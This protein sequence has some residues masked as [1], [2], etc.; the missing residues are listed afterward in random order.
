MDIQQIFELLEVATKCVAYFVNSNLF[1]AFVA[2]GVGAGVG[3][4]TAQKIFEKSSSKK[5]LLEEIRNTNAS[6]VLAF[7]TGNTFIALKDQYVSDLYNN[8][9]KDKE[10]FIERSELPPNHPD[11]FFEFQFN[12]I[13]INSPLSHERMLSSLMFEKL[14]LETKPLIVLGALLR[15]LESLKE[16]LK[17]RNEFI[18]KV[19]EPPMSH[20]KLIPIYFG[21]KDANGKVDTTYSDA[22]DAVYMQCDDCIFYAV[23]LINYLVSHGK[24]LAE[25][26][27][28]GAPE[29]VEPNFAIA[30][31]KGL[32]PSDSDYE[33]WLK[34]L[35]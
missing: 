30:V 4:Y 13:N 29:I 22:V 12:F 10:G 35:D 16:T 20:P 6:I 5:M 14:T 19:A 9:H 17:L 1:I 15:A 11:K 32:M 18:K 21:L 34:I 27:G 33:S 26:Y 7:D 24:H 2:S 31:Q 23:K 28:R 25:L 8:Y 3:A